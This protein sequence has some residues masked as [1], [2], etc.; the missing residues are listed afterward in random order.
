[1]L[2]TALSLLESDIIFLIVR[3]NEAAMIE[4]IAND[5]LDKLLLTS[6]KD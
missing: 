1:M 5:V 4:V 3:G 2:S 6:S